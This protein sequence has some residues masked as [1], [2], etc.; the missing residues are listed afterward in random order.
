[1]K[2]SYC[3]FAITHLEFWVGWFY[4]YY[5]FSLRPYMQFLDYSVFARPVISECSRKQGEIVTKIQVVSWIF[6]GKLV[7]KEMGNLSACE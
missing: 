4:R 3:T 5:S 1:M 6:P 2:H 7:N